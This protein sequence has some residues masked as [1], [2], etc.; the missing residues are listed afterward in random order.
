M[1]FWY[2][3]IYFVR[4]LVTVYFVY[5]IIFFSFLIL[6]K[7]FCRYSLVMSLNSYFF[8]ISFKTRLISARCFNICLIVLIAENI[9]LLKEFNSIVNKLAATMITLELLIVSEMG[10]WN[11]IFIWK[12]TRFIFH[13]KLISN[14]HMWCTLFNVS[15]SYDKS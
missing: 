5:N 6:F 8:F 1:D 10:V 3:S 15:K 14:C 13:L 4:V 12:Y 9:A 2:I 11:K 7:W